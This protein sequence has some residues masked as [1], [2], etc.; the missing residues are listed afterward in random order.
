M[1]WMIW[2][3]QNCRTP[4]N[5]SFH[6]NLET[7]WH[8]WGG[9][10]FLEVPG[11]GSPQPPWKV[12]D[13]RR[14]SRGGSFWVFQWQKDLVP[15]SQVPCARGTSPQSHWAFCHVLFASSWTST[16]YNDLQCLQHARLRGSMK[17]CEHWISYGTMQR[18][19]RVLWPPKPC[20]WTLMW[21]RVMACRLA[22]CNGSWEQQV[23]FWQGE[24]QWWEEMGLQSRLVLAS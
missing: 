23:I 11:F 8:F 16:C 20:Q 6:E 4:P 9:C 2:G 21:C 7:S 3:S 12:P 5:V 15:E 22:I 17:P 13:H 24:K 14:Y 1:T 10:E 18:M 19:Q